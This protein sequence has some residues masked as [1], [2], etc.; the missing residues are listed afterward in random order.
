VPLFALAV[1]RQHERPFSC[2]H[3]Y[4]HATHPFLLAWVWGIAHWVTLPACSVAISAVVW[5]QLPAG[6][7]V[8]PQGSP[9]RLAIE[10]Y[11]HPDTDA[12]A[13]NMAG[14]RAARSS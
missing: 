14:S 1:R 12:Y 8:R 2:P 4:A 13:Q 10:R 6:N 3:Q 5:N 11:Q 7:V 9:S